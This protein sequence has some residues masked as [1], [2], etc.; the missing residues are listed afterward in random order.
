MLGP[1]E[2]RA[3]SGEVLEVGGTR[4]RTLPIAEALAGLADL[5]LRENCPERAAQLL[6]ASVA[7]RGSKTVRYQMTS[8]SRTGPGTPSAPP[9][10][11]QVRPNRLTSPSA[12]MWPPPR[13]LA[14]AACS[15]MTS[16]RP[17]PAR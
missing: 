12:S 17:S 16:N 10:S 3:G 7:V 9:F 1:L 4:L 6:G 8:G 11:A 5:V 2:V 14:A 15:T 13:R